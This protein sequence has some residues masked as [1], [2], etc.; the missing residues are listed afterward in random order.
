MSTRY[1][2]IDAKIMQKCIGGMELSQLTA[3]IL[4]LTVIILEL[5]ATEYKKLATI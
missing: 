5:T 2:I 1:S 4:E 3:V